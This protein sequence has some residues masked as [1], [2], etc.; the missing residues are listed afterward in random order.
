MH[1][2]IAMRATT[3]HDA[4]CDLLY[5]EITDESSVMSDLGIIAKEAKNFPAPLLNPSSGTCFEFIQ[6]PP[7]E[8][9][10]QVPVVLNCDAEKRASFED[11]G[12]RERHNQSRLA[13][14]NSQ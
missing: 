11:H 10:F 6:L 14:R 1:K 13:Q 4:P 5:K 9:V 2:G 8:H 7:K 3:T 12:A